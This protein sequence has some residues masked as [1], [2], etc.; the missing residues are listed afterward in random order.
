M[1]I[2]SV[3]EPLLQAARNPLNIFFVGL[4][5]LFFVLAIVR[6]KERSQHAREFVR[7]APERLTGLGILGTFTGIFFGLITFNVKDIDASLPAL[8][9]GMTTAFIA[10]VVGLSLA[11]ILRTVHDQYRKSNPQG[12][13]STS[14]ADLHSELATIREVLVTSAKANSREMEALR[15]AVA[16]DEA[17]TLTTHMRALQEAV[18]GSGDNTLVSQVRLLRQDQN[19]NAKRA[20]QRFAEFA[21]T[22]SELGS[23]A[24]VEAL[25]DVI[26]DFN[27]NL[28]EQFGDNFK[29]LN[30][31]V[32]KLVEWQEQYR[33]QVE[34]LGRQF[35]TCLKGVEYARESIATIATDS[36]AI[37]KTMTELAELMRGLAAQQSVL[38]AQ[39]MAYKALGQQAIDAMPTIEKNLLV[40]T[41]GFSTTVTGGLERIG[42]AELSQSAASERLTAAYDR[43]VKRVEQSVVNHDE[44]FKVVLAT[45]TA[46][47][48]GLDTQLKETQQRALASWRESF[49]KNV[50]AHNDIMRQQRENLDKAIGEELQKALGQLSQHLLGLHAKLVDDYTPL[51]DRL[52]QIVE[53]SKQVDR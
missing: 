41:T 13:V 4:Q 26:T 36:A 33:G 6:M 46:A 49:D 45:L 19:D 52:R 15:K 29:Q 3:S 5:L 47:H 18:G 11:L 34:E 27:K 9:E 42:A 28:T 40:L 10:S 44:Q 51:T 21:K 1:T 43:L 23:K 7:V 48:A 17:G 20:E 31:A 38:D 50:A 8:L 35:A 39:L 16:G 25:R 32:H 30:T 22:V 53:M 12:A 24:L 2:E 14:V 37:P